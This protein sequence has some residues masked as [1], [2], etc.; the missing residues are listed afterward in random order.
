MK[1]KFCNK[2]ALIN[3]YRPSKNIMPA[4][5]RIA[6]SFKTLKPFPSIY[7]PKLIIDIRY[8]FLIYERENSPYIHLLNNTKGLLGIK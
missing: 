3:A 6:L 5:A 8:Y 4:L 2:N 7:S 1:I